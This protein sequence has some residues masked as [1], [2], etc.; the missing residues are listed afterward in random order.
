MALC[1]VGVL[2]C[3]HKP[4]SLACMRLQDSNFCYIHRTPRLLDIVDDEWRA[5]TLPKEEIVVAGGV[6]IGSE[7]LDESTEQVD[8]KAPQ[9]QWSDLG[10]Q[11]FVVENRTGANGN[12]RR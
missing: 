12:Q 9:A 2:P 7:D 3:L 11:R 8:V 4:S 6:R 1:H 10:L 5:E